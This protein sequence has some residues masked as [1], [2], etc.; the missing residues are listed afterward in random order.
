LSSLFDAT[1]RDISLAAG[2]LGIPD[3]RVATLSEPSRIIEVGIPLTRD[4]GRQQIVRG[5]RVQHSNA[6]GPF[7]GGVRFHPQVR[8][9]EVKNLALL[10]TLKCAVVDIPFGGAK[11]GIS[12]DPR[13]LS[14]AELE[15]LARG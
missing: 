8:L 5:W 3:G 7:K 15:R 13:Q 1:W 4:D 2:R 11:G 10:M 6:R 9:D 14:R 12:I